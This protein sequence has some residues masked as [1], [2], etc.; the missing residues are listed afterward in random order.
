MFLK[1]NKTEQMLP[2]YGVALRT[3]AEEAL[4][5]KKCP[6]MTPLRITSKKQVTD[7]LCNIFAWYFALPL[8]HV[9][10]EMDLVNVIERHVW[11][12]EMGTS[13]DDVSYG[14]IFCGK[15]ENNNTTGGIEDKG[16]IMWT[17]LQCDLPLLV[18]IH[19]LNK[20]T[21]EKAILDSKI[22]HDFIL[23]VGDDEFE[24]FD[25]CENIEQLSTLIFSICEK[26][27]T[28]KRK[29]QQNKSKRIHSFSLICRGKDQF[30][31]AQ[32]QSNNISLQEACR[33]LQVNEQYLFDMNILTTRHYTSMQFDLVQL[34]SI[35]GL[36]FFEK[37]QQ[38]YITETKLKALK[39]A[40]EE[41]DQFIYLPQL[42]LNTV[43]QQAEIFA[44]QQSTFTFKIRGTANHKLR[45]QHKEIEG[46]LENGEHL[47]SLWKD[48]EKCIHFLEAKSSNDIAGYSAYFLTSKS[49]HWHPLVKSYFKRTVRRFKKVIADTT[50]KGKLRE[51]QESQ[52]Q[53]HYKQPVQWL[54]LTKSFTLKRPLRL[55]TRDQELQ[56]LKILS[57][58][59]VDQFDCLQSPVTTR[60]SRGNNICELQ[61]GD[62][63]LYNDNNVIKAAFYQ[64]QITGKEFASSMFCILRVNEEAK[65]WNNKRLF[66][67]FLSPIY[68]KILQHT[69]SETSNNRILA[70]RIH[71]NKIK[72][73]QLPELSEYSAQQLDDQFLLWENKIEK[74]K[75]M[76]A[77]AHQVHCN[78]IF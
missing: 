3:D 33:R 69:F 6:T 9:L 51:L 66:M 21:E 40:L 77:E 4:L 27:N 24:D 26:I 70:H 32:E 67:Y 30:I 23:E 59:D 57:F 34:S 75:L 76:I 38:I 62:V 68:Q 5:L 8:K 64:D 11:A 41:W 72:L 53:R 61:Q 44:H 25:E 50:F 78:P 73:L 58:R 29:T 28:V 39:A 46:G 49:S 56:Q 54:D 1:I 15:D 48:F 71:P 45:F 10:P 16:I 35:G 65:L 42:G 55:A 47:L 37:F 31:Q 2:F 36:F 18:G 52:I 19:N 63:V 14:R 20:K 43:M 12:N 17:F 7:F 22:N 74:I 60:E 13:F